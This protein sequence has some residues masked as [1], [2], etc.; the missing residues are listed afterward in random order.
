MALLIL[1][2]VAGAVVMGLLLLVLFLVLATL[3]KRSAVEAS[4]GT[5]PN[6]NPGVD[7]REVLEK[8]ARKEISKEDAEK[9]LSG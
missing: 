5:V 6:T 8:L 2:V 7:R 3:K 9:Q 1:M 4:V